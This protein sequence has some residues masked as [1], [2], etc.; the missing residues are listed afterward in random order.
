MNIILMVID[1]FHQRLTQNTKCNQALNKNEVAFGGMVITIYSSFLFL[2]D[3][4]GK[5]QR[6]YGFMKVFFII[7]RHTF[8]S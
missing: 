2:V 4:M 7:N 8:L 1:I 6:A 5:S 3:F